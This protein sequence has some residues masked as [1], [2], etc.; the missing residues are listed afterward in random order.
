MVFFADEAERLNGQQPESQSKSF[1]SGMMFIVA[2]YWVGVSL[3][4]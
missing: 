2:G 3:W 1:L 4:R